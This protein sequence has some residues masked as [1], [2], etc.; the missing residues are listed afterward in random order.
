[1]SIITPPEES[2]TDELFSKFGKLMCVELLA[3]DQQKINQWIM[4][5]ISYRN[6]LEKTQYEEEFEIKRQRQL[7][8]LNQQ[9]EMWL[10]Y[11]QTVEKTV[12]ILET[13]VFQTLNFDIDHWEEYRK[14]RTR[15]SYLE[16]II[17]VIN[18][19]YPK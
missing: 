14:L 2:L 5:Q 16:S 17:R 19:T 13:G 10:M 9:I 6:S 12:K 3:L 1:M 8:I 15:C 4:N 11:C 18:K 7:E